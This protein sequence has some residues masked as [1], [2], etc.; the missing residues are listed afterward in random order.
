MDDKL[1]KLTD[2]PNNRW[3]TLINSAI[4]ALVAGLAALAVN[5]IFG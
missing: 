1:T 2:T 4:G 3:N 5:G